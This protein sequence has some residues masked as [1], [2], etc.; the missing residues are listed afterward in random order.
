MASLLGLPLLLPRPDEQLISTVVVRVVAACAPEA[1]LA[2]PACAGAVLSLESEPPPIGDNKRPAYSPGRQL[3]TLRCEHYVGNNSL[4]AL[5]NL[6]WSEIHSWYAG[7]SPNG[8]RAGNICDFILVQNQGKAPRRSEM[9]RQRLQDRLQ[10]GR[11]HHYLSESGSATQ[12]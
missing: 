9:K 2:T 11:S 4:R 10:S 6:G 3:R 12:L 8:K 7:R 1:L 5:S